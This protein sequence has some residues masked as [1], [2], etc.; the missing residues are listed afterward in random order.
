LDPEERKRFHTDSTFAR[1]LDRVARVSTIAMA[2]V[3]TKGVQR[4][5]LVLQAL[6]ALAELDPLLKD[7]LSMTVAA[8]QASRA[9]ISPATA[10]EL[11]GG[12]VA[13]PGDLHRVL[14]EQ[15]NRKEQT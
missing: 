12:K 8:E 6:G 14:K 15:Q 9:H 5:V 4:G 10:F 3:L 1:D 7:R 11:L 13:Q 2:A